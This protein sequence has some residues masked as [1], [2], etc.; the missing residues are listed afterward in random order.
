[1]KIHKITEAS[2][3][4]GRQDITGQ[5]VVERRKLRLKMNQSNLIEF[6]KEVLEAIPYKP[7]F[8]HTSGRQSKT[9]WL[10]FMK[11]IL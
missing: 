3:Y 5:E 10:A 9:I 4:L 2:E 11:E 7:L 1:M 8:G 6:E